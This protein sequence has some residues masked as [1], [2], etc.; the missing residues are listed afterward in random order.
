M[1]KR[2]KKKTRDVKYLKKSIINQS[3]CE[4]GRYCG[5]KT[6]QYLSELCAFFKY[7]RN[8]PA[9]SRCAL[10]NK[11]FSREDGTA[12]FSTGVTSY[13]PWYFYSFS[14]LAECINIVS[15]EELRS[16]WEPN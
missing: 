14:R 8:Y 12:S 7:N 13:F 10:F 1:A 16:S 3:N 6:D 2:P 9:E 4:F 5:K 11:K 15:L